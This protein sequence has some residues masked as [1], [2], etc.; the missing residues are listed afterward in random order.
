MLSKPQEAARESLECYVVGGEGEGDDDDD[1]EEEE[2]DADMVTGG[3][4]GDVWVG[5]GGLEEGI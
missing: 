1:E 3:F 4:N 5:W 2:E